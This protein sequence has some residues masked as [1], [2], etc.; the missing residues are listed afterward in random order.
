MIPKPSFIAQ[1]RK[2]DLLI[3]NG[4]DLEIGWLP[5][6]IK[7]ANNHRIQPGS[8]GFLELSKQVKLIDIPVEVSRAYEI[9]RRLTL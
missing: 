6:V 7:Q 2:A 5:P 4:A 9:V 1:L 8:A 3:I